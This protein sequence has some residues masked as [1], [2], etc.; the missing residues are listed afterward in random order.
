MNGMPITMLNGIGCA[1]CGG[2]CGQ[3]P[4]S[5]LQN[6]LAIARANRRNFFSGLGAVS[7]YD[8]IRVGGGNYTVNQVIDK[9]ILANRQTKLYSS[10]SLTS[11]TKGMVQAGKPIGKV[12]SYIK[13]SQSSDGNSWLMF[14]DGYLNFFFVPNE[15]VSS[16]GLKDQ[17]T[18]TVTQEK[19][20]EEDAKLKDES[21]IE[22]YIKKYA[23]KGILIIGGI[24]VAVAL[25]KTTA[26]GLIN[27]KSKSTI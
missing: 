19:K 5:G 9:T 8:I 16:E 3:K 21:P 20:A 11:T 22:Y 6:D 15:N 27:K 14:E 23:T 17:G 13:P 1:E 4:L 7:D 18:L 24:I 25:V 2:T 26:T 10:A 12:Y